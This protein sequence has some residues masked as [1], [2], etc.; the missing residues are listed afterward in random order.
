MSKAKIYE[1]DPVI[2]PRKLWVA[3]G[4]ME[5]VLSN[6]EYTDG[7]PITL[8]EKG[9]FGV[10]VGFLTDKKHEKLGV[11][12]YLRHIE[13]PAQAMH[14]AIHAANKIFRDLGITF[15]LDEDEHYAY[16]VSWIC[17]CIDKVRTNKVK[18]I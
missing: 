14:E 2:Y 18:A 10:T 15:N 12:V 3:T 4:N 5:E 13:R 17:E 1:F 9:F 11:L 6:F 16:F 7:T 8:K